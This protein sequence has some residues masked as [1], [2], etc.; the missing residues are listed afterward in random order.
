MLQIVEL[1]HTG[2]PLIYGLIFI[3]AMLLIMTNS[4]RPR[5]PGAY[6]QD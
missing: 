3:G 1:I 5:S 4:F 2:E 6:Q